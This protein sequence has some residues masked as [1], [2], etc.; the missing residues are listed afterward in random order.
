M[1]KATVSR[2]RSVNREVTAERLR[3]EFQLQKPRH[4][5]LHLDDQL[6]KTVTGTKEDR[7]AVLVSS[8]PHYN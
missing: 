2:A 6:V 5:A 4:V 8:V 7:L 3:E 1:F